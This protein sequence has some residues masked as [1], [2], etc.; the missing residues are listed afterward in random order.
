MK[1][2]L[3]VVLICLA[4]P[5]VWF[6]ERKQVKIY[7][8]I[9][10]AKTACKDSSIDSVMDN[11]NFELVHATGM[12]DTKIQVGDPDINFSKL[13][14]VKIKRE[15]EVYQWYERVETEGDQKRY[16]YDKKWSSE[17]IN[18]MHFEDSAAKYYAPSNPDNLLLRDN[19]FVNQQLLLGQYQ[20]T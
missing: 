16:F 3:G 11:H 6:N 9:S 12:M 15:V 13:Q 14:T 4:L 7:E 2:L 19:I 1:F 18:Q 5:I 17:K 10:K 8:L 20:I